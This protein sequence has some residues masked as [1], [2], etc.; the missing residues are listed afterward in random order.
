MTRRGRKPTGPQLVERL[1]GSP[2]AKTRLKAILETLTG[3]RSI[4]EV[5]EEL[6]IQESMFHKLRG[7]VLQT[8]LSRLEPRSL[9]RPPQSVLPDNPQVIELEKENQQLRL[10]LLAAQV[11]RD[12]VEQ[13]PR[14]NRPDGPGKKTPR[15]TRRRRGQNRSP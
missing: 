8:A 5:C 9:G 2:R 11:R 7:E 14:L 15:T 3:Q 13:L 6:G 4:P 12:L 1:E 10:D